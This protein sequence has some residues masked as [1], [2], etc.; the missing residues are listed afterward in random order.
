M[1]FKLTLRLSQGGTC[2]PLLP[3]PWI[4]A[5]R[6]L[7]YSASDGLAGLSLEFRRQKRETLP[8][9]TSQ[10]FKSKWPFKIFLIA[11]I[12]CELNVV[13]FWFCTVLYNITIT[14]LQCNAALSKTRALGTN[15]L[16]TDGNFIFHHCRSVAFVSS[17]SWSY[18]T[19]YDSDLHIYKVV[20]LCSPDDQAAAL[21]CSAARVG[22][23]LGAEASDA[24][25]ILA[26]GSGL[27]L[28]QTGGAGDPG[29]QEVTAPCYAARS[30]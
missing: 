9:M 6:S 8:V 1:P 23:G 20:C 21:G 4:S 28:R 19:F 24:V 15:E 26:P 17:G 22:L 2:S 30:Q 29:G 10:K 25:I 18:A 11:W 13:Y 5:N 27:S 14:L 3:R 16:T 12:K 7:L